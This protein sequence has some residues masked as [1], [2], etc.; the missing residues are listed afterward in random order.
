MHAADQ[1]QLQTNP[2]TANASGARIGRPLQAALGEVIRQ[3]GLE[4]PLVVVCGNA[5]TG[6]TLLTNMIARACTDMG[7]CARQIDRGD[8]MHAAFGQCADVL[9]I[10]EAD[11]I[12][13]STLHTLISPGA[14]TSTITMVFLCLPSNV[15]RFTSS[16]GRAVI[17]E[18]ASLT[19]A[20]ARNYLLERATSAGRPDLFEGDALELLI[21]GSHGSP[22]V[23]RSI[24]SLAFFAA[25][26]DGSPRIG[27]KHVADALASQIHCEPPKAHQASI[28]IAPRGEIP[29]ATP[30]TSA[31]IAPVPFAPA[32][33]A[34]APIKIPTIVQ[35]FASPASA[36]SAPAEPASDPQLSDPPPFAPDLAEI[37][38]RFS[39]TRP[40]SVVWIPRLVGVAAALVASVAIA[41]GLPSLLFS[42]IPSNANA[43]NRPPVNVPVVPRLGFASVVPA[44]PAVPPRE[45]PS[46]AEA[47]KQ[48]ADIAKAL[49]D[50]AA[51]ETKSV[52][53]VVPA[54]KAAADQAQTSKKPAAKDSRDA[55]QTKA[56]NEGA[57]LKN[58]QAIKEETDHA[59]ASVAL[60]GAAAPPASLQEL[61]NP[62]PAQKEIATITQAPKQEEAPQAP[63]PQ[64]LAVLPPAGI[65]REEDDRAM[66]EEIALAKAREAVLAKVA[67]DRALAAKQA[68]Q[69]SWAAQRAA[70]R[71]NMR[72]LSNSMRGV[73]R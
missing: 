6:K 13:E 7:L 55:D 51:K 71:E 63:A 20:D 21:E 57:Y 30:I 17:I 5:G 39:G 70:A 73:N 9:L 40:R 26:V 22:R 34:A 53:S 25:A 59:A 4:A 28:P 56:A 11:S 33:V 62:T 8:L 52:A 64:L 68:E 66:A 46:N 48:T 37:R 23:L 45:T 19:H 27:A 38:K 16:G 32:P 60:K 15:R 1:L 35:A 50:A 54:G 41:E 18:L 67:A 58:A 72:V 12:T 14:N 31:P 3:I 61:A 2:F 42:S 69:R 44:P 36:E 24:A 47:A 43:S 49:K 29:I 65:Q 10:D